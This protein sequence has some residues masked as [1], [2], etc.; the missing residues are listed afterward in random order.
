MKIAIIGSGISGLTASYLL[1]RS[2]DITLFEKNDYIGG[3]TH[4]HEID[5]DGK[6]TF[7]IDLVPERGVWV[8]LE[9]DQERQILLSIRKEPRVPIWLVLQRIRLSSFYQL[10]NLS[11]LYL[12]N[13]LRILVQE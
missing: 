7:S 12:F 1:N 6:M 8:R 10:N 13:K 11:G 9:K 2:H 5:H 3:H 4:T